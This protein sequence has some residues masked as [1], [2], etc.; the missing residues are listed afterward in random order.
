MTLHDESYRR[1]AKRQ[2]ALNEEAHKVNEDDMRLTLENVSAMVKAVFPTDSQTVFA[3]SVDINDLD[4]LW[5]NDESVREGIQEASYCARI[6]ELLR[7][8]KDPHIKGDDMT[9]VK[10][11]FADLA[12]DSIDN[13]LFKTLEG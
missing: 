12:Y 5:G 6:Y 13:Y 9:K 10:C 4:D 3:N 1:V 2:Q 11:E 7:A 8:M